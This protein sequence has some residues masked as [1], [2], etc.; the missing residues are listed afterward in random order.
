MIDLQRPI[1][2]D[3]AYDGNFGGLFSKLLNFT[4]LGVASKLLKKKKNAKPEELD[5]LAQTTVDEITAQQQ[6]A[7]AQKAQQQKMILAGAGALGLVL[8]L[9]GKRKK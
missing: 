9:S 7:A 8:L 6:A 2:I 5:A 4:T 3:P 1:Y